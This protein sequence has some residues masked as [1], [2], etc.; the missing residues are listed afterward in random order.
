VIPQHPSVAG[1][2]PTRSAISAQLARI[3]AS[4]RFARAPRLCQLLSYLVENSASGDCRNLLEFAVGVEVFGRG[5][6]FDPQAD[7]IVRVTVRRLRRVLSD[8]YGTEGVS[9]PIRFSIP[10][11]CYRVAFSMQS[12]PAG[13]RNRVQDRD[14][15]IPLT[16]AAAAVV[17]LATLALAQFAGLP[18]VSLARDVGSKP[19]AMQDVLLGQQ[20]LH[21]RGPG[22]LEQALR[23]FEAAISKDAANAD[24]W[25]GMAST[26]YLLMY[27]TPDEQRYSARRQYAALRQA[28]ALNPSQ[29]EANARMACLLA[30]AGDRS[31][32]A[33]YMKQALDSGADSNLVL[34]VIAGQEYASGNLARALE[35][36]RR[37]NNLAP[38][39]VASFENLAHM[40]YEAGEFPRALE[41]LY[42]AE[43]VSPLRAS[44]KT[45]IAKTLIL[46]GEFEA[47]EQ[48]LA[49]LPY[50]MDKQ[51]VMALLYHAIGRPEESRQALQALAAE[52]S[53]FDV[54]VMLAE[55]LAYRGD[56]AAAMDEIE[57]AYAQAVSD[58]A[59]RSFNCQRIQKLLM[60]P[61]LKGLA[62]TPR[63]ENWA[64]TARAYIEDA[65][66]FLLTVAALESVTRF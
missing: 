8:Y 27:Q 32:A 16:L 13:P 37:A 61:Y 60:S 41:S 63:F 40:E 1:E 53:S 39:D 5:K 29:P 54:R 18:E 34:S 59:R 15:P 26:L 28:L 64:D 50:G 45:D 48:R 58:D 51:Q 21:R 25:T 11:G 17:L 33:R 43:Q 36:L 55:V 7:T 49:Q 3:Q 65:R 66:P 30:R 4:P 38:V 44:V 19:S 47:A 9:D 20:L 10:A 46:M 56:R 24:A 35:L 31:S 6:E 14:R 62:G 52:A 23:T 57:A 2:G 12:P 22:D 42:R